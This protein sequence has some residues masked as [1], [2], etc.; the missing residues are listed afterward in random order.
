M[1]QEVVTTNYIYENKG[2][3]FV[4]LPPLYDKNINHHVITNLNKKL[5]TFR[6][7]ELK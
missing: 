2:D 7:L 4:I 5:S 3:I 6:L 1:I